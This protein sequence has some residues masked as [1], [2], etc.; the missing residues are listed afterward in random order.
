MQQL[1]SQSEGFA[2]LYERCHGRLL[3]QIARIVGDRVTAEDI[4]HD[5]F[6]KA[7]ARWPGVELTVSAD[8]W[9]YRIAQNTAYD[10]L[11]RRRRRRQVPLDYVGDIP[12]SEAAHAARTDAI[13]TLRAALGAL[14]PAQR[15]TLARHFLE[16]RTAREIAAQEG[17]PLAT[18]K[19]RLHRALA[20]LRRLY[21]GA[22]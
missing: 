19:S 22:L 4:C 10:E 8:A 18:A 13:V 15:Q 1:L 6:V 3:S 9:L 12:D 11:R 2:A 14:P 16:G 7:L 20:G 21:A 5:S 17:I